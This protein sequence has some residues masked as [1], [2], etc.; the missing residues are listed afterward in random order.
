MLHGTTARLWSVL[1]FL[2]VF[3]LHSI[4]Q[5][6]RDDRKE[7]R[8][9]ESERGNDPGEDKRPAAVVNVGFI[10]RYVS[11]S[12]STLVHYPPIWQIKDWFLFF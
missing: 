10:Q 11:K 2:E 7:A 1:L 9:S 3:R 4:G 5:L 12:K 6:E 8:E